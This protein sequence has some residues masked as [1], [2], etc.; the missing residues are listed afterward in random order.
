M[1]S[2]APTSSRFPL[3]APAE[4]S[5][6]QADLYGKITAGPR[7]NGPF[8]IMHD[9]GS[10]A[11][12]FNA[13]LFAPAIGNAVQELGAALRFGGSIPDRARELVICAVAAALDSE[14]EWYAHSHAAVVVGISEEELAQ[15]KAGTIPREASGYE[16]AALELTRELIAEAG[17]K[18]DIHARAGEHLGHG[19]VTELTVLVGYYRTLAGLLAVA[20][21]RAP[22]DTAPKEGHP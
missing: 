12:P 5:A 13:L 3:V 6:D 10:L 1:S 2:P 21:V 7:A 14:Y 17:V 19:G 16:A 9:D 15:L 22:A 18:E 8:R 4:L 11:G 20:D